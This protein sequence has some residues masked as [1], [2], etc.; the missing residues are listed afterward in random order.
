MCTCITL[1]LACEQAHM[2][3]RSQRPWTFCTVM[4]MPLPLGKSNRGSGDKIGSLVRVW[5]KSACSQA[6]LVPSRT[7]RWH[8]TSKAQSYLSVPNEW[9]LEL[10]SKQ[11]LSLKWRFC[12]TFLG[13]TTLLGQDVT[14][15]QIGAKKK[16]RESKITWKMASKRAALALVPF[17]AWPKLKILF[18]CLSLLQNHT[19]TRATQASSLWFLRPFNPCRRYCCCGP[20]GHGS[21]G[22][23]GPFVNW[24]T[25]YY[26]SWL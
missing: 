19:E 11:A 10:F 7:K 16:E 21:C 5:G 23:C 2:Q 18:L 20:C 26:F 24:I 4:G 8:N 15:G 13:F 14:L 12:P 22:H 3:S 1:V 17:F 25:L 9:N 6:T